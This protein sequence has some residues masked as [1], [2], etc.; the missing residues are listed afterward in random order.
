MTKKNRKIENAIRYFEYS[1]DQVLG[2]ILIDNW[3]V[4]P[5]IFKAPKGTFVIAT[6][7]VNPDGTYNSGGKTLAIIPNKKDAIA[8][9]ELKE[10][11]LRKIKNG[12][13]N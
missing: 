7:W 6:W 8:F 9:Y 12:K 5:F 2:L 10:K 13:T 1:C 11:Q 3:N 4:S